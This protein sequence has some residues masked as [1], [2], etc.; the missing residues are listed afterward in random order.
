M[1]YEL[2]VRGMQHLQLSTKSSYLEEVCSAR[3]KKNQ[4]FQARVLDNYLLFYWNLWND[5]ESFNSLEKQKLEELRDERQR[6]EELMA[7][8][9]GGANT[10]AKP[11]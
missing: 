1:L 3:R 9:S 4:L 10:A 7:M 11:E 2:T 5:E 6:L 8:G